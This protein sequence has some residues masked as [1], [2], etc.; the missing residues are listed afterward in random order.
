MRLTVIGERGQV[1]L[2]LARHAGHDVLVT[3]L[4]RRTHDLLMASDWT[5]LVGDTAPDVIVNA[6]A[7]TDV[8]RAEIEPSA[9]FAVNCEGARRIAIA[10]HQL[11]CPL[12]HLSTEYVFDGEQSQPYRETDPP[13]PLNAYGQS[14]LAGERAVLECTKDAVVLRSSWVYSASGRNFL[15]ALISRARD[16]SEIDVIADRTGAPTSAE[17]LARAIEQVARH[18][19]MDASYGRG[20]FHIS[21]AGSTT[22]AEF[23]A[24]II[25]G[26]PSHPTRRASVRPIT[27][28]DLKELARRPSNSLL[29]N[30][31]ITTVHNITLP[32]WRLALSAVLNRLGAEGYG[33]VGR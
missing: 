7:Y 32:D 28:K 17:E 8:E 16:T 27:S 3:R 21:C 1:A 15:T 26:L 20:I 31:L 5:S 4:G 22:W 12:I 24:E 29:D 2:A 13:S 18:L 10:A 14:K 11:G 23:A 19:L 25:S 6:A 30:E 33:V 9:A